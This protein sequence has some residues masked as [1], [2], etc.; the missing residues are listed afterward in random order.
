MRMTCLSF[1]CGL[2]LL[3]ST[4]AMAGGSQTAMSAVKVQPSVQPARQKLICRAPVHN[5]AVLPRAKQCYTKDEWDAR[6]RRMQ[7][8]VRDYQDRSLT[9]NRV[10]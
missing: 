8:S 6:Q 1:V 5:G 4:S 10:P 3:I 2:G 7:N 9:L